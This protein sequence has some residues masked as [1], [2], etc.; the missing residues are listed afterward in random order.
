MI[1]VENVSKKFT[2]KTSSS[3][4]LNSVNLHISN[5]SWTSIVGPSGSGKS[6]L[7]NIISG[8]L[9]P[10]SGEIY[11]NDTNIY[12]LKEQERSDLRRKRI[13]FVFQDFKLLPYYSVIDNVIL[14]IIH[15]H[16]KEE[17]YKQA[18][19]LLKTVG[20]SES[21]HNR[22]PKELSGGEKQRVAIARALIAN[23]D[24]LICD[25]PTGNLDSKNRDQIINLLNSLREQGKT[26]IVVTHDMG[27]AVH[28]DEIYELVNGKINQTEVVI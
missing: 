1:K 15:E 4:V 13:G 10:D 28:G 3:E 7:L 25:E 24:L 8:L 23:P 5:G 19:K 12:Q 16:K 14:P 26:M 22:L 11:F 18:K 27:V 17:L 21:I 20:I 6:T 9:K 2:T